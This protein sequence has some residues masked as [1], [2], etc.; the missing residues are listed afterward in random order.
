MTPIKSILRTVLILHGMLNIAQGLYG[1]LR[2]A[3]FVQA[4]G[5]MFEGTP[6]VAVQSIGKLATPPSASKLLTFTCVRP[7]RHWGRHIWCPW[8]YPKYSP[9]LHRH[10][11]STDCFCYPCF[12]S[13]GPAIELCCDDIR[14]FG[15]G[16]CGPV[17][18]DIDCSSTPIPFRIS[19]GVALLSH[20]STTNV[21]EWKRHSSQTSERS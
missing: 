1:V 6:D 11:R 9:F 2:P 14:S 5:R 15:S 20:R 21:T 10:F 19:K 8:S 18:L 4:S 7:R 16:D 3:D 12:I 13:I 17:S